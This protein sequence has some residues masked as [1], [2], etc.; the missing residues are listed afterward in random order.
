MAMRGFKVFPCRPDKSPLIKDNLNSATD[1]TSAIS[2]WWKRWPNALVGL[3]C[4]QNRLL[5]L[6]FDFHKPEYSDCL[7]EFERLTGL[8]LSTHS[9]R[10]RTQS[11]GLH[12][13]YRLSEG[14]DIR[15]K[16]L[17]IKGIDVRAMGQYVI[18]ADGNGYVLQGNRWGYSPAALYDAPKLPQEV[19]RLLDKATEDKPRAASQRPALFEV[20]R[21]SLEDALMFI[22]AATGKPT[23]RRW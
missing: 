11:G 19:Q 2:E 4:G 14:L 10:V 1:D 9:C 3:P 23:S 21:D 17:P 7:I 20:A 6:D 12:V 22:P 13:Y 8:D 15:A 5:V 18:A 16:A